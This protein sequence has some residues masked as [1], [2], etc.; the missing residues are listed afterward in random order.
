MFGVLHVVNGEENERLTLDEWNRHAVLW[1]ACSQI[2]FFKRFLFL[3]FFR[4]LLL[5][6]PNKIII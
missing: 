4:R 3:K 2:K 1:E 6:L 5:N